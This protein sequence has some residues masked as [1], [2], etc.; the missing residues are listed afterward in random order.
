M[1]NDIDT[2]ISRNMRYGVDETNPVGD[3]RYY[4]DQLTGETVS[5][6][7]ARLV[8]IERLRL[9]GWSR[10]YPVWDVSYCYGRL[11]DGNLVRVD[12]GEYRLRCSRNGYNRALVELCKRAGKYG[13]SLGIFDAVSTLAG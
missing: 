8:K 5:L 7:D 6:S 4:L 13:K 12:L 11:N 1:R 10:E 9:I 2:Q 3:I